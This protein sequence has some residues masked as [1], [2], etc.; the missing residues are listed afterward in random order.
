MCGHIGLG[1][2]PFS[3]LEKLRWSVLT[4]RR[5]LHSSQLDLARFRC[6]PGGQ[7]ESV[8][9]ISLERGVVPDL[10]EELAFEPSEL[11][12]EPEDTVPLGELVYWVELP[13]GPE[14]AET[15]VDC[16][17]ELAGAGV[18]PALEDI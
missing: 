7:E 16:K 10:A 4:L 8:I 9:V 17:V 13:T 15:F 12:F 6:R 14:G 1:R 11:V 3:H 5:K 18:K 2:V